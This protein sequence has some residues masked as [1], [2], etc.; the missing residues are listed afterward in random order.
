MPWVQF[1]ADHD[2]R[3]AAEPRVTVAYRAGMR[4]NVVRECADQAVSLGRARR[5]RAPRAGEREAYEIRHVGG[6]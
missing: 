3:P 4:L 6:G 1:E 5:V 2:F